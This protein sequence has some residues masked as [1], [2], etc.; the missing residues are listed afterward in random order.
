M[1]RS[2]CVG[3]LV[4]LMATAASADPADVPQ[5]INIVVSAPD[6]VEATILDAT[7]AAVREQRYEIEVV[8][9]PAVRSDVASCITRASSETCMKRLFEGSQTELILVLR[10]QAS[11][12]DE[13]QPRY[14][15]DAR[16]VEFPSGKTIGATQRHCMR[17]TDNARLA[18]H[19]RDLS[20]QLLRD[21]GMRR[22]PHTGLRVV[23]QPSD[24]TITIDGIEAGPAG[25][26]YRVAPGPH[27][28][29]VE[30]PRHRATTK[31]IDLRPNQELV[32]EVELEST[33]G[34]R[35]ESPALSSHDESWMARQRERWLPWTLTAASAGSLA[36][37]I[38]WIVID[39]DQVEGTRQPTYRD[40]QTPGIVAV[41]V[42][43]VLGGVAAYLFYRDSK[44]PALIAAPSR[45][46][47][48]VVWHG[49][50]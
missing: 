32:L 24:A 43:A 38:T 12:D 49:H 6:D 20:L 2:L 7:E 22:A 30:H 4:L 36:L 28:V 47:G 34:P 21:Q 23:T 17:C 27:E 46:G 39:E 11:T 26:T 35:A 45:D 33:S 48:V 25:E 37:G 1:T 14:L 18:E 3:V 5:L 9:S 41:S 13:G 40:S 50:F 31:Q 10:A 19:A 8:A 16:L 15:I 29:L 44:A 42:G